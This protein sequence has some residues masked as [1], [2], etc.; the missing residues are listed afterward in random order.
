MMRAEKQPVTMVELD[1]EYYRS[2][3]GESRR[4]RRE[5]LNLAKLR[6]CRAVLEAI[7]PRDDLSQTA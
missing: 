3:E 6:E 4:R 7:P 5:A 2:Y 1:D